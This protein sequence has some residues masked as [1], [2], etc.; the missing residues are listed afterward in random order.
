MTRLRRHVL[1]LVADRSPRSGGHDCVRVGIVGPD[2]A[3]TTVFADELAATLR[4]RN[5]P[6]V[7]VSLDDFHNVRAA[8]Y[9]LGRDSPDGFC[10]HA[11]NYAR[12]EGAT[13]L[14]RRAGH[15]IA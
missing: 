14:R 3:G 4:A 9:R 11:F 15:P 10:R 13:P 2:G 5:R 8:R 12:S 1:G 7:R 6:V